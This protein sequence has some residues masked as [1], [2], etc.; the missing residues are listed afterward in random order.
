MRRSALSALGVELPLLP[1]VVLGPLPGGDGW[2]ERLYRI[3]LDVTASGAERDNA[4]TL[5]AA[6]ANSPYRPVKARAGDAAA[7]VAAGGVIL[8]ASDGEPPG[9]Y[10]LDDDR[11]VIIIDGTAMIEDPAVIARWVVE[12]ARAD[13]PSALWVAAGPGLDGLAPDVVEA[14]L[15]AMVDATVQARLALAKDQFDL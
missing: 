1:T 10:R 14:K 13:D 5:G 9:G 4:Q 15:S 8:E 12:E 11:M 6:I 7:L 2:A 3:G